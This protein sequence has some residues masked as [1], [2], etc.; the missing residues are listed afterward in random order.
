[1]L[2][3]NDFFTRRLKGTDLPSNGVTC[4]ITNVYPNEI[5]DR[6]LNKPVAKTHIDLST[7]PNKG[8]HA[9]RVGSRPLGCG[10]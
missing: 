5:F 2:N 7:Y 3:A 9:W 1:M 8:K 6:K 4:Q 10:R